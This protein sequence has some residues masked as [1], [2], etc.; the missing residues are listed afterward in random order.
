MIFNIPIETFEWRYSA[1]WNK[2]F[3]ALFDQYGLEYSTIHPE[4][5]TDKIT[6]GQFLDI[7][8]TNYFKAMQIAEISRRIFDGEIADGDT[9]FFHDLWFP[10]I[11]A[12]AYM[13]D[14]LG[15]DFKIKGIL[16]AGTWDCNDFLSQK[17]MGRWAAPIEYGWLKLIDEVYVATEYHKN[18]IIQERGPRNNTSISDIFVTGLPYIITENDMNMYTFSMLKYLK[19]HLV[20]FPHRIAPEKQPDIFDWATELMR[21]DVPEGG[22]YPDIIKTAEVCK[23]KAEYYDILRTSRVAVSCALQE[24]W[25]IAMWESVLHGCFPVVP[26]RLAYKELYPAEFRYSHDG[27]IAS[28][29]NARLEPSFNDYLS[30]YALQQKFIAE[31]NMAGERIME[32]LS[33]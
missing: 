29:I 26:D 17:K 30:L 20:V 7:A 15:I 11:E 24:T 28:C 3:P 12:L 5:L 16:H 13:R 18:L 23:T 32:C 1:Q 19:G 9:I 8:G 14:G 10:G 4:P 31:G 21:R 22:M 2:W 25:G 33:K 27:Q 6:A